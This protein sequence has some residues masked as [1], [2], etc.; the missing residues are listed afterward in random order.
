MTLTLATDRNHNLTAMDETTFGLINSMRRTLNNSEFEKLNGRELVDFVS[1]DLHEGIGEKLSTVN[2]QLK[3]AS[4]CED[5]NEEIE[6]SLAVIT[7]LQARFIEHVGKEEQLLFPLLTHVRKK[8]NESKEA[9]GVMEFIAELKE[10]HQWM[11]N[12][13][14]QIREATHEYECDINSCPSHK[15]AYA[16][17][18]D[19]E[20]DFTHLFFVEEQY[21]FPYLFRLY[22]T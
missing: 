7:S 21:L 2:L 19:L 11:K 5:L 10:E 20:Q 14:K 13:L 17:L 12:Q 8:H 15:L 4:K 9:S 16:Q 6:F 22:R 18:N 3:T 1:N